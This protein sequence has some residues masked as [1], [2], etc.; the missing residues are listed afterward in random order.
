MRYIEHPGKPLGVRVAD[1]GTDGKSQEY[2]MIVIYRGM[3]M[4]SLYVCIVIMSLQ[5]YIY[6]FTT[7]TRILGIA[8]E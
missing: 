8:K 4:D 3:A 6:A 7:S 5:L 1:V 2:Q